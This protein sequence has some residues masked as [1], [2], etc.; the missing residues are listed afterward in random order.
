MFQF[1]L[2]FITI[3]SV[4]GW[5]NEY[6]FSLVKHRQND[7][8]KYIICILFLFC[9]AAFRTSIVGN[10]TKTY[11]EIFENCKYLIQSEAS[12][13]EIGYL[14]YNYVLFK[15]TSEPRILLFVTSAICFLCYGIFMWR[16]SKSPKLALVFFFLIAFGS[17]MNTMR[18]CMA[19]CVLLFAVDCIIERKY[20]RF[21][22]IVLFASLFH[23]SAI[24]FLIVLPLSFIRIN[25]KTLTYY[26][27]GVLIAYFMFAELLKIG[28]SYF[29]M[30][31]YYSDGKY[32]EGDTRLA[33]I[34]KL[35]FSLIILF[36][37]YYVYKKNTSQVW[38]IS[39]DG[40]RYHIFLMLQILAVIIDFLSLKVN[41]LDRLDMYF[42][43]L[44]FVLITNA[45]AL[46]PVHSRRIV[47]IFLLTL[48]VSYNCIAMTLR[49][50]W[51]RIYPI[52]LSWSL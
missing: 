40:R 51:N 29:S 30:Y 42:T 39:L 23:I 8:N 34:I 24:L 35:S 14:Y 2:I 32:F 28:F 11:I 33:S 6:G 21:V 36:I 5:N 19:I 10:D 26:T 48:Y 37:G 3:V 38:K 22:L 18:Q 17:T 12:R 4:L 7:K 43:A 1:L 44:S 41:L 46:L 49:P 16:Y 47:T 9:L 31:E 20:I 27:I 50:D 15:I 45:I 13:F 25:V 52:E